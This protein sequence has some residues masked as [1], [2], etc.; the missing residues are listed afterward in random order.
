MD[1]LVHQ[2]QILK[3]SLKFFYGHGTSTRSRPLW[4]GAAALVP[5][6][7]ADGPMSIGFPWWIR[8]WTNSGVTMNNSIEVQQ[9]S[10][11]L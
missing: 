6:V 3:I 2:R 10:D 4:F 7:G 9:N 8:A 5:W 11:L 1:I